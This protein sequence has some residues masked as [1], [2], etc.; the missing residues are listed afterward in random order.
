MLPENAENCQ[1]HNPV[2]EFKNQP[3]VAGWDESGGNDAS[4]LHEEVVGRDGVLRGEHLKRHALLPQRCEVRTKTSWNITNQGFGSAVISV[5][6]QT[7]Y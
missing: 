6:E 3:D 4:L 7:F 1:F 2:F 5:S